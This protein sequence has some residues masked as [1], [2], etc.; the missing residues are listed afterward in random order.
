MNR[1][2]VSVNST[3]RDEGL[4]LLNVV[5]LWRRRLRREISSFSSQP[6]T[7]LQAA[8]VLAVVLGSLILVRTLPV[9]SNSAPIVTHA[10]ASSSPCVAFE[11][12]E[13]STLYLLELLL[14]QSTTLHLDLER[15]PASHCGK[16]GKRG[17]TTLPT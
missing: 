8:L 14:L 7:S 12:R 6:S 15:C 16:A 9:N 17:N 13:C 10:R 2:V 1:W 11:T 4:T 3:H 5:F